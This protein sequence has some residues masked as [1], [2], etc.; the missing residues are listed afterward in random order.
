ML[1]IVLLVC[2]I[3]LTSC[4]DSDKANTRYVAAK[5]V[6][7]DM[8]SIVDVQTGEIIH[9]DEFKSQPSVIVNDKFC[10]K[11]ESGLYDYFTIGNVTKPLNS[12]SYLYATAF[13]ENDVALAVL[14]GN[15]ISVI[16]GQCEVVANLDKS[17]VFANDFVNGY[18]AVLNDDQK[19]GYINE[20][21]E[22]VIK[23]SYDRAFNFSTDGL[24]IVGKEVNDSTNKYFAIDTKGKELF[25]FS[26]NEYKD[27]GSFSHGLIP[28]QKENDEVV[29]LDKA[30]KKFC[31]IGK[32]KGLLPYWLGF[33][34][35][36]IVFKDGE[37]YGL[38]NEKGEIV[39]RAKYDEFIPLTRINAKYYLAKK[40][41]KYGVV[42]K[43]DKVIIP[44]YYTILGFINKD[45]L[46]VGEG[47][48]FNLMDKDLTD[49]G[50][51][52]YTNLSFLT[53]SSIHSNYFNADKEAR[54]IISNITD[55][56]FFKTHKGMVLRDFK[57]KLSGLKYADMDESTLHD[58]D[59]PFSFVYGFDRNLSSQRYEYIYGY[60]F[61]TSPEYNYNAN[62]SAVFAINST[63]DKFQPE[64][65][66]ALGKA[67]DAQIQISG[68]KPVDGKPH[69]F[70][71]DKDMAVALAYNEGKIT[72]MCAY[73]P[74]YMDLKVERKS[75]EEFSQENVQVDYVDTF[76]I[77]RTSNSDS[78]AIEE[79]IV[80]EK[81]K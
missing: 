29:L 67:F 61:P 22:I 8:W 46:F 37:A 80:I 38:K 77:E 5:L 28:V 79:D 24:A 30:G 73:L 71:N 76:G 13:N 19:Q 64:S 7:S 17:I 68:F 9:K 27:F 33:N 66:E 50:Q 11:N 49:V 58:Y 44:F 20:K 81:A 69:W 75:R 42:D 45:I 51:N 39:I 57:D 15:G 32:W 25:S 62:L 52:N 4:T 12:E 70:K 74:R 21:G 54:K 48:S 36:V 60:R 47:K 16:N 53:G 65:E 78:T 1:A 2:A 63:F 56:T 72:V 14:K 43:D 18:A 55:S 10:V 3:S 26:S 35:E 31:S 41:D 34:D 59:Y 23:P 6:D 40:Q